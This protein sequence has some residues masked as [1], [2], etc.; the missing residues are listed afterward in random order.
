MLTI[1]DT[2]RA[3]TQTYVQTAMFGLV[4]RNVPGHYSM[5]GTWDDTEDFRGWAFSIEDAQEI[6]SAMK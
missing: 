3:T 2:I 6:I 1:G 4:V 5:D